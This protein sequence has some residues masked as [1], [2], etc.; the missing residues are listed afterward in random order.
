M[1]TFYREKTEPAPWQQ[2][3]GE[4]GDSSQQTEAMLRPSPMGSALPQSRGSSESKGEGAER[5]YT[6][7]PERPQTA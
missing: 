1:L 4:S 7:S 3:L 6:H 2:P 5:K